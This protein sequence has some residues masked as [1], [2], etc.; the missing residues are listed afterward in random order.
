ML[1]KQ[2][3]AA[4]KGQLIRGIGVIGGALL[5]L[6]GMIGAGIFALPAVLA[7]RAG[8]LSPWLFLGAGI[9]I[10][11][12]VLT[13]AELSSYFSE[14]GGPALYA[15]R[16]FG[17][18]TGFSIGWLYYVSR[19]S[20]IAANSHVMAKYLGALWPWFDTDSGHA[21]VIVVV[22]GALTL[23]NVVGVKG[24]V[25]TLA[26]F[27]FFKLIPL[28]ILIVLGL[29]Y[30]SPA[31]LF[32]DSLPTIED[33]GGTTL[34]L[35]YAFIGF[36][37]ILIT[38]GETEKPRSTIPHALVRTVIAT[39]VFYFLISLVYVAVLPGDTSGGT[40]VDVGRKLAGPVGAVAIT[41]AAVFSIGG[42]LS[43]TMLAAPRLTLSLAENRL[44]PQWFGRI[45]DKYSSPAN[46]IIFLGGLAAILALSGSFVRL[47][48]ASSLTR[49]ITFAVCI[50]ALPVIKQQADRDA[51]ERA[52]RLKGGYTLP[53]IALGL[54]VW[55]ASHSSAESW[56]FVAGLFGVG[57]LLFWLEQF[58]VRRSGAN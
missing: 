11:I 46:S 31:V 33:L 18:L 50:A 47:A 32:P 7:E 56:K 55:M 20:A 54:C 12:V 27:T 57:L 41:L 26:F 45:H 36:E 5:V 19:A 34:L 10:I 38:A 15:T 25:R 2:A 14:S 39:G 44:L 30:A 29:Q 35:I 53:I 42:N 37:S 48:I 4:Q 23:A 3:M 6:N 49:L 58:T 51:L 52:Y 43:S 24:G 22:C 13:L 8:V 9:L 16:A 40:L 21:V 17:P 28:L 1:V